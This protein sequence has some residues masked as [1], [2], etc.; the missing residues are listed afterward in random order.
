M[1]LNRNNIQEDDL[2]FEPIKRRAKRTETKIAKATEALVADLQEQN[3]NLS[4]QLF[5]VTKLYRACYRLLPTTAKEQIQKM[6]REIE[7]LE[8]LD[9][10]P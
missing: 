3:E 10:H 2:S 7:S 4:K 8:N 9:V 1:R 5:S 6:S